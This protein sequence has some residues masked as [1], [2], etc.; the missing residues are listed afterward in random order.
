MRAKNTILIAAVAAFAI[1][2]TAHADVIASYPF[3]D[4]SPASTDSE[5]DSTASDMSATLAP[6]DMGF[7]GG[8]N[9][10]AKS[11]ALAGTTAGDA[12]TRGNFFSFTV[13]PDSGKAF[14]L[15]SLT[16][17]SIHNPTAGGDTYANDVTM[18]FFVR[19]S[20]DSYAANVGSTTSVGFSTDGSTDTNVSVDLSGASFQNIADPTTFR[21]YAFESEEISNDQ[22]ARWDDVTLNGAVIPE[23]FSATLLLGGFGALVFLRRRLRK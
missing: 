7:S 22:G 11:V 2:A 18:N 13:T 6:W 12:V 19:S 14:D 23:P 21:L 16:Y 10:Y 3:T 9:A 1:A 17:T 4:A 5:P 8:G 20:V 15:S